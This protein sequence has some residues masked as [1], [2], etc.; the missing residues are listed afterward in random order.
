MS[1]SAKIQI[2]VRKTQRVMVL[3]GGVSAERSVSLNSGAAVAVAARAAGYSVDLYDFDGDLS[4]L[5]ERIKAQKTEVVFNALHG[6]FG[7]DG[8]IQGV[9]DLM[10]IPYSHSGKLASTLAMDKPVARTVFAAAGL[11]IAT[12]MTVAR[13]KFVADFKR[14]IEPLPRPYII[15]PPAEGSSFGVILVREGDNQLPIDSIDWNYGKE[16][17]V[18][19]YIPG[20]EL[21]VAVMGEG[22]MAQAIGAIEIIPS[23][24]S[25]DLKNHSFFDYA[26][27]YS[28]GGARH[29]LPPP[30]V[31]QAYELA[32]EIAV[33]AHRA[34]G[35]RG[36]TRADLRYDDG[37]ESGRSVEPGRLVLLEVN[38]QPGMTNVSLVPEIALAAGID[39]P[40]LITWMVETAKCN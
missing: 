24:R 32:L 25:S 36:V 31:P 3:H 28:Q 29:I 27:K 11:P 10:E 16:L 19:S 2:P 17:L 21:T 4:R 18:E 12:G 38:S 13:D 34:L 22:E 37:S 1:S 35:C 20:R 9:L 30:I 5:I 40:S 26:A 33:K 7:E 23:S 6:K 15:K 14:G 39:F 8:V